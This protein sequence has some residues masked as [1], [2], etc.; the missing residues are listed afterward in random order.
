MKPYYILFFFLFLAA[1]PSCKVKKAA[2]AVEVKEFY[3]ENQLFVQLTDMAKKEQLLSDFE[4]YD[5]TIVKEISEMLKMVMVEF[6][7]SKISMQEMKVRLDM[8]E[9]VN[10]TDFAKDAK[11]N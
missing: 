8:A 4:K 3:S 11:P 10:S 9:Y 2:K 7:A 5:L 6:D 1:L